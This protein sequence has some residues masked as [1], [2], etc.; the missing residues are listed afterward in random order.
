MRNANVVLKCDQLLTSDSDV[1][2]LVLG[3]QK[4][5]PT[6]KQKYYEIKHH[7]QRLGEKEKIGFISEIVP[8]TPNFFKGVCN[9]KPFFAYRSRGDNGAYMGYIFEIPK[10]DSEIY[11]KI[12]SYPN[13]KVRCKKLRLSNIKNVR[14]VEK[15]TYSFYADGDKLFVVKIL[16]E[17]EV[18]FGF[19]EGNMTPKVGEKLSVCQ[20]DLW[21]D[22]PLLN[23][24]IT[25]AITKVSEKENVYICETD[26]TRY[27]IL[28]DITNSSCSV[29]G[30][31]CVEP[32]VGAKLNCHL[33]HF[34]SQKPSLQ[35][36]KIQN[37]DHVTRWGNVYVVRTKKNVYYLR[38][39]FRLW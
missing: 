26:A 27:V 22:K 34:N 39:R 5:N 6:K 24:Q 21:S 19:A 4:A 15:D 9:N 2:F 23:Y 14:K 38:A 32:Q 30:L 31:C 11:C 35:C 25:S 28:K 13:G 37:I 8:I 18:V 3:E 12:I 20:I 10:E 33:V 36:E 29:V 17:K 7:I 16:R 1:K